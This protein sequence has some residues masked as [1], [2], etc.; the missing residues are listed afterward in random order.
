MNM[1]PFPCIRPDQEQITPALATVHRA[2]GA[3]SREA[4]R[5]MLEESIQA[6][7]HVRD[8]NRGLYI[9]QCMGEH[10][11]TAVVGVTPLDA[12]AGAVSEEEIEEESGAAREICRLGCQLRPVCA[13]VE[14]N[15]VLD[16][17]VSAAKT[18]TPVYAMQDRTGTTHAVWEILRQEAVEAIRAM[19]AQAGEPEPLKSGRADLAADVAAARLLNEELRADGTY[20]GREPS[21]F[22]MCAAVTEGDA[23]DANLGALTC[24]LLHRIAR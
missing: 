13:G 8:G 11:F 17:I 6:G 3:A 10:G 16:M 22:I 5:A 15:A 24:L 7:V 20:T 14:H 1:L 12:L 18:S 9:Y 23:D 2:L 4:A 21:N 19:L